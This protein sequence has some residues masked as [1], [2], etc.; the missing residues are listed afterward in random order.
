MAEKKAG[1]GMVTRVQ[2]ATGTE[3]WYAQSNAN[4]SQ[5]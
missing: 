4:L 1:Y 5:F 3:D 2:T